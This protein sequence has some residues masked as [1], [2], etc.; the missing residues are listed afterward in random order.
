MVFSSQPFILVFLPLTLLAVLL[1]RR[2]GGRLAVAVTLSLASFVFYGWWDWRFLGLLWASIL[3][4]HA[5]GRLLLR[6]YPERLRR[7]LLGIGVAVNL[8]VLCFFK[9]TNFFLENLDLLTGHDFSALHIILPLGVSFITFQKIAFLVDT[10]RD[11]PEPYRLADFALFVSFFPQLIA[12][13]IVHHK[14]IIPQFQ[15][16]DFG[17]LRLAG[18][19][20][21]LAVFAIGLA[22]KVMIADSIARWADPLFAVAAAGE[23]LSSFEAWGAALAYGLQLYFDFSGYADMAI[24]LG[25]MFG[26]LLPQNFD[27]P[28]AALSIADFWRRWHMTLSRFLRDYLYIP[29]GGSRDGR[30]RELRNLMVTMLLGGIWH[31]AAWAFV[32][33]GAMHGGALVAQR[34]WRMARERLGLGSAPPPVGWLLTMLLVFMAWVPFRAESLETAVHMWRSMVAGPLLPD[35]ARVALGEG[36]T[37]G[38]LALGFRIEGPLHLG[39][40]EWQ[41][42]LPVLGASFLLAIFLPDGLTLGRRLTAAVEA[43]RRPALVVTNAALVAALF[44]GSLI[45]MSYNTVFLYYQF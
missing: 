35:R 17:V 22:K 45:Y 42:A 2:L 7:W 8:G 20:L 28:Y 31:G 18:L 39:L 29:L 4:N 10:W 38:L 41:V 11:R 1:A 43:G 30:W 24:G 3:F 32:A 23:P 5:W 14:E 9:Y 21:G 27:R 6:P 44:V 12:G 26:L 25:L 40:Q 13:P 33:W 37:D 36:L 15:H 34:L 19:N 16:P